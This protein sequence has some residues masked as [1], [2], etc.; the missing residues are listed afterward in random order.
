MIRFMGDEPPGQPS[1]NWKIAAALA[2]LIAV[3]GAVGAVV[4]TLQRP[5]ASSPPHPTPTGTPFP[6]PSPPRTPL[7]SGPV[8]GFG[9]TA[10]DDPA[11]HQVLVFGGVDSYNDTWLWNG[12]RW[13]LAKPSV[14]PAGRFGAAAA[15]DP[16]TQAVML[17]GGRL[18][19]GQVENDTW[20]WNG[21]TWSE[22]NNGTGGPPAGEGALMAWD[23]AT[24]QMVL[25]TS[26]APN[27]STTWVWAANHWVTQPLHDLPAA[28]FISGMTFDPATHTLL[29]VS[30]TPTPPN[31]GTTST[32]LWDAAGW[33]KLRA[34]VAATPC[35]VALDVASDHPLLCGIPPGGL[36]AQFWSWSGAAWV[37]LSDSQLSIQPGAETTDI[38]RGQ[39]LMLGPLSQPNQ[40][41]PQPLELWAWSGFAWQRLDA[42][43]G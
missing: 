23:N 22:L 31:G 10:A 12:T 40:G 20:S 26:S 1:S 38:D 24:G 4:A 36:V 18:A 8:L 6:F 37:P 15:Y 25:V 14:S 32:W 17:F 42:G 34:S 11:A 27:A 7:P 35:G 13:S 16:A 9:F 41:S 39:V 5:S 28:T 30:A 3:T 33:R 21:T 29:L 19:P 2:V 43:A